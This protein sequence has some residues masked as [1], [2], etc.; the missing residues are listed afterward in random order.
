MWSRVA[1]RHNAYARSH[2][3]R[4]IHQARFATTKIVG[5][6]LGTT[7]SCVAVCEIEGQEPQIITN[8]EGNRTTP[9]IVAFTDDG[10]KLVGQPA[11]RQAVTNPE[12]TFYA[13]KRLI[14][15][16]ASDAETKKDAAVLSYKVVS[17]DNGDAWVATKDGKKY[18]PSQ[19]GAFVLGKKYSPSQVG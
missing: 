3:H 16:A 6:D 10:N 8:A 14:G 11:K 5:V 2:A 18:S 4:I 12:N 19:V 15:R 9:S 13:T 1:T 7:N 17:G